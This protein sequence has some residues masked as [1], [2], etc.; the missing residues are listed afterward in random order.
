MMRSKRQPAVQE[1]PEEGGN[2]PDQHQLE[3]PQQQE[4]IVEEHQDVAEDGLSVQNEQQQVD[5]A[6]AVQGEVLRAEEVI[7]P[8]HPPADPRLPPEALPF[9]PWP[10]APRRRLHGTS[11]TQRRGRKAVN[12]DIA[13]RV[14]SAGEAI[15]FKLPEGQGGDRRGGIMSATILHMSKKDQGKWPR[16]YNIR[17]QDRVDMSVEL[18]F[19]KLWWVFRA[20][21]WYPGDQICWPD[22]FLL[23]LNFEDKALHHRRKR[24]G[25]LSQSG[26]TG[27]ATG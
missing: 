7:D 21:S 12:L 2:D 11:A 25:S 13:G 23:K 8:E 27:P 19:A 4:M 5:E 14:A 1:L 17:T 18:D 15:K 3:V 26:L 6:A 10:P 20:G 9:P 16:S 24:Y 22:P